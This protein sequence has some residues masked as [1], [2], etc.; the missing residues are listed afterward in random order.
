MTEPNDYPQELKAA[1]A[2]AEEAGELIARAYATFVPI[3]NAR[4][5]ITTEVDRQSQEIILR[6]LQAHFPSDSYCAEED[7]PAIQGRERTGSRLWIIDP[8]DGTRG[9]AMK[10]GEFSVM[11]AFL[12]EGVLKVGVVFEPVLPRMTFAWEGGGCWVRRTAGEAAIRCQVSKVNALPDA[13]LTQSHT[14]AG[15]G[16]SVPVSVLKPGK[17]VET[18]SA[19]VKLALVARGEVDL[20]ANTYPN[21]SDW[22]IAAGHILVTEAGGKVSGLRGQTL[23]YGRPGASQRAGLLGSNF[24]LHTTAVDLLQRSG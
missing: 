14:R 18:Y 6:S 23:V 4:A 15:A 1:I 3:P 2:A 12:Q 10:N 9:F 17:V 24:N 19:G 13:T 8:I 20:Y 11:I 16:P 7:T 21:F 22:D 5:D